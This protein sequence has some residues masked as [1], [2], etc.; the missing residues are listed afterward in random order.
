MTY[1]ELNDRLEDIRIL[2]EGK[3]C[4]THPM[5]HQMEDNLY[6]D[7]ISYVAEL[8]KNLPTLA[9]KAKMVLSTKEMK[10]SRWYE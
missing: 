6:R 8:D 5:A 3:Q 2:S 9:E 4:D 1:K 7:F 10:F